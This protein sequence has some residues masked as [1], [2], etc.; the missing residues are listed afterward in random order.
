MFGSYFT[1][2]FVLDDDEYAESESYDYH[3]EIWKLARLIRK[4]HPNK[5]QFFGSNL[6]VPTCLP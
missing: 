4:T 1:G 2:E 3:K 6:E 5:A